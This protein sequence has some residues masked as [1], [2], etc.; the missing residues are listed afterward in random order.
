M[1]HE[2]PIIGGDAAPATPGRSTPTHTSVP[3]H[4]EGVCRAH[5]ASP[6]KAASPHVH[7]VIPPVI[8]PVP[9]LALGPDQEQE[10]N[11]SE[12]EKV[13]ALPPMDNDANA[14]FFQCQE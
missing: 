14:S 6:P 8:N 3:G 10:K 2:H 13:P 1:M 5:R 7:R 12:A 9:H 11:H 4:A